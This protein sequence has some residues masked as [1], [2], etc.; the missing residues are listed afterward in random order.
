MNRYFEIGGRVFCV[1][2]LA[3]DNLLASGNTLIAGALRDDAEKLEAVG[4]NADL[5]RS[6]GEVH[7]HMT[8]HP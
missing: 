1:Q 8:L 5:V 4:S 6:T 7:A 2:Q 3:R